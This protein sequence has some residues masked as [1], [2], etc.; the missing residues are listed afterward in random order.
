MVRALIEGRKT[1]T[2][3]IIKKPAALDALNA[4]GP[5]FLIKPGNADLTGYSPGD[6][7][8]VREEVR[9]CSQ[10]D[11]I[12]P[13]KLSRHEPR[14]YTADSMLY[15]PACMMIEAGKRRPPMFMPRWASR[16]TLLVTEARVE[17]L[18][19]CSE[20]DA[21]AEG[22]IAIGAEESPDPDERSFVWAF[23]QLWDD[24]NGPGAWDANPWVVAV[25]F[26]VHQ[27]NIDQMPGGAA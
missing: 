20:A 9:F 25:S 16:L 13:S 27:C 2:R 24:I 19:D 14:V 10:M 18:Q 8:Y 3:R 1:Q 6:R 11:E 23:S 4:F 22:V 7:L 5:Q 12:K 26:T 21:R 15:E 17:R